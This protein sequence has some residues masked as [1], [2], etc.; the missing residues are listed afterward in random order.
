MNAML[1][2][3]PRSLT[4]KTLLK[5]LVLITNHNFNLVAQIVFSN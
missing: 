4:L 3:S 5:L 1:F 2:I